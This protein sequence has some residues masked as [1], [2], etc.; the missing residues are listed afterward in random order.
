VL[1]GRQQDASQEIGTHITRQRLIPTDD[2]SL[3]SMESSIRE[4]SLV[5]LLESAGYSIASPAAEPSRESEQELPL[6]DASMQGLPTNGVA[7]FAVEDNEEADPTL[8]QNRPSASGTGSAHDDQETR[9]PTLPQNRPN[10][11]GHVAA[12]TEAD[13]MQLSPSSPPTPSPPEELSELLDTSDTSFDRSGA[14]EF[15]TVRALPE[16]PGTPESYETSMEEPGSSFVTTA[17]DDTV[18][19]V[20]EEQQTVKNQ[21][22]SK[23]PPSSARLE[24][25]LTLDEAEKEILEREGPGLLNYQEFE[26]ILLKDVREGQGVLK[27]IAE[28]WLE[29]AAF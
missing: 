13:P 14:V 2:E 21:D 10:T 18:P 17:G 9:D 16:Y 15:D 11:D 22:R 1:V 25:L 20:E 28:S 26:E 3:E 24:W 23:S 29:W 12:M 6:V 27:G 19:E 8:P 4:Q 5:D 7:E